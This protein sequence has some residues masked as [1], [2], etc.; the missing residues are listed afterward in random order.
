MTLKGFPSNVLIHC[1]ALIGGVLFFAGSFPNLLF[2]DGLPFLA[3]V[4]YIPV[5][6]VINRVHFYSSFVYGAVY[7]YAAYS[8]F[9]YWLSVF[10]PLAG[11]IVNTVYL[12]YFFLLFPVLKAALLFFPRKGYLVQWCI[13]IAFEYLRTLGFLGY[14]YGIIGYS[15]WQILPIIQIASIFGVWGVSAL[16]VFPAVFIGAALHNSWKL[17]VQRE[18]IFAL[19]WC[20]MFVVTIIYGF[21]SPLDYSEKPSRKIALIQQNVDP[22]RGGIAEYRRNF[23]VLRYLSDQ[24]L[25]D[26]P[27]LVVWSETAFV[28][29]IDWHTRY[30]DDRD[31]YNL[32]YDFN[33]YMAQQTVPFVVGNDD[34]R[35]EPEKS[36]EPD[37]RVDY[38]AVLLFNGIDEFGKVK[39]VDLYRK[40]HLVPFTEHFPYQKQ[41]PFVYEALKSADTH[42]WEKGTERTVFDINGIRFS[43]P[44]CFEDTFGYL[45]RSFVQ[46]GAELLVNLSN[47]AWSNSLP[48]QMQHLSMAVFRAIE[49]KRALVRS[50]ASGQTCA[51]DP[52]G[53]IL[54]MAQP[55]VETYITVTVPLIT[56]RTFYTQYGDFLARIAVMVALGTLGAGLLMR[57]RR[58]IVWKKENTLLP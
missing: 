1:S 14:S 42:F 12:F 6:W 24:A 13:W 8:L 43:T 10:H 37:G 40:V 53:K 21:I 23:E 45:S 28:P 44:I 39:I 17:F 20:G 55:F 15:Q 38:N 51:I 49:N 29:R 19:V 56:E 54:D 25:K 57:I 50:T 16:I 3:W 18:K 11:L 27:D 32:V 22:W 4:A 7:G 47:D 26:E 35:K 52:N 30:R 33:K 9:N 34:A 2:E 46:N 48:A 58:N 5:F 31:S 36:K 41:L